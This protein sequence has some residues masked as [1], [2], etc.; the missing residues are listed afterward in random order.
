MGI[1]NN[2][3]LKLDQLNI[4]L[5]LER[6]LP[7]GFHKK[8]KTTL[9]YKFKISW[10]TLRFSRT[11]KHPG[12]PWVVWVCGSPG[13]LK[14]KNVFII[15][16]HLLLK[17]GYH[18]TRITTHWFKKNV[19]SDQKLSWVTLNCSELSLILLIILK[20]IFYSGAASYI[21]CLFYF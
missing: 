20:V 11:S 9:I 7:Y 1:Q 4:I 19:L 16:K 14:K 10:A 3:T 12:F 13:M 18:N 21:L 15:V 6:N 17:L 2:K 8:I 5:D